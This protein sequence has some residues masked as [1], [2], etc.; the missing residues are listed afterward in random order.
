MADDLTDLEARLFEWIRQ[1]DFETVPWSTPKAAKAFKVKQ[2]E[3]Y[4]ALSAL[5]RKVPKRIQISYKDGSLRVA[6]E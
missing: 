1:S 2:D 4:D 6:A 5:T 3:I